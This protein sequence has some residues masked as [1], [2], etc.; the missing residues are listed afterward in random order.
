MQSAETVHNIKTLQVKNEVITIDE[1]EIP[2][3]KSDDEVQ[4]E[5]T[6]IRNNGGTTSKL[7][8]YFEPQQKFNLA[9]QQME[10]KSESADRNAIERPK[11]TQFLSF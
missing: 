9:P 5:P 3:I 6:E 4:G 8:Y 2:S 1:D 10:D 11:L 7:I